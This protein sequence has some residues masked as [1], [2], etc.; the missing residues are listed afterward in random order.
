MD[1]Q[2]FDVWSLGVLAIET[3]TGEYL[4]QEIAKW[5]AQP[6][7]WYM[8]LYGLMYGVLEVTYNVSFLHFMY[9]FGNQLFTDD[10]KKI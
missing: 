8:Q 4:S 9:I 1:G 7:T 2:K 6:V 3:F 10:I 5:Q